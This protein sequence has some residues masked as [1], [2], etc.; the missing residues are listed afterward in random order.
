MNIRKRV[1]ESNHYTTIPVLSLPFA[2]RSAVQ[3]NLNGFPADALATLRYL[4]NFAHSE[5][6]T[7]GYPHRP[8][9]IRLVAFRFF[10]DF[11]ALASVSQFSAFQGT[12]LPAG[13]RTNIAE[14]FGTGKVSIK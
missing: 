8:P 9:Y 6:S 4:N 1:V 14:I 3:K 5:K 11:V 12:P 7:S 2:C 13:N 10:G